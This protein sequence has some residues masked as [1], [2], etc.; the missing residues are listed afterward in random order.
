MIKSRKPC[1]ICRRWFTPQPRVRHRQRICL[2]EECRREQ[3][4]RTQKEWSKSNPDYWTARN[5][6]RRADRIEEGREEKR[7][8]GPPKE[9]RGIPT[10]LVQDEIDPQTFVLI[11]YFVKVMR[12]DEEARRRLVGF[13]VDGPGPEK[14]AAQN[15]LS[16]HGGA[17]NTI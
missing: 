17:T 4:R 3:K 6:R 15:P 12:L 5:L 7:F 11:N 10:D 13:I 9:L 8:L 1:S 2:R 14:G 16:A